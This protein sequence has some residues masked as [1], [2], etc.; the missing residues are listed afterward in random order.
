MDLSKT[1]DCILH[2]LL[3]AKPHAH[4]LLEDAVTFVHSYIKRRKLGVEI[5]DTECFSSTFIR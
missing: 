1:F 3:A 5:I 2:D 4:G